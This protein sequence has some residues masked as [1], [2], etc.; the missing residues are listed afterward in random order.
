VLGESGIGW[1]PYVLQRMDSEWEDQFKDLS[2]KMPP[3]QVVCEN[4]GKLYGLI[5]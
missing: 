4:A 5:T 3:S 2:L 1:I